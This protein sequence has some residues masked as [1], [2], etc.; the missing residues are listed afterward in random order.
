MDSRS[1][2]H[3]VISLSKNLAAEKRGGM[4]TIA[5]IGEVLLHWGSRLIVI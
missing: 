3:C 2:K 4:A 5:V 1:P